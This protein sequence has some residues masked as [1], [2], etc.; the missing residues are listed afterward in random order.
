M[1]KDEIKIAVNELKE[2]LEQV[3]LRASNAG[4]RE[5]A[6]TLYDARLKLSLALSDIVGWPPSRGTGAP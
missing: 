3:E 4:Y 5:L 6:A 1:T 2:E